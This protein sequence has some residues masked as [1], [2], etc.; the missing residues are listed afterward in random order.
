MA[1]YH[2][3]LSSWEFMA[4]IINRSIVLVVYGTKAS[5]QIVFENC[6]RVYIYVSALFFYLYLTNWKL[7]KQDQFILYHGKSVLPE[8]RVKDLSMVYRALWD[9]RHEGATRIVAP[10]ALTYPSGPC[11]AT[12]LWRHND[13]GF[14]QSTPIMDANIY[15]MGHNSDSPFWKLCVD[16]F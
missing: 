5:I 1:W 10:S 9:R 2:S 11:I 16:S 3:V 14:T 13:S 7:M 8:Q 15:W 12:P 4:T 6:Y